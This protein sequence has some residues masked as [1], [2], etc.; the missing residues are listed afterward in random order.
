MATTNLYRPTYAES[1]ALVIGIDDYEHAPPLAHAKNDAEAFARVLVE[2]FQF[3]EANL[4]ILT[5][6]DATRS[7][8]LR[9]FMKYAQ[10]SHVGSDDRIIVFFAGHGHTVPARRGETGFLVPADGDPSDL[11]TLLRWDEL[12]RN[13]DLIPAKHMFF[14]M[15]ACYGG[16]ALTR[17]PLPAGSMRFLRDMLQ[18][19]SRQVLTAGKGDEAVADA[20]GPRPHHSLFTGHLLDALEG[21]AATQGVIT[22][23]GVMAYVYHKVARDQYS[24]QTPHYGFLEGDGDFVF[25]ANALSD[26]ADDVTAT[27]VPI[28]VTASHPADVPSPDTVSDTLKELLATPSQQI[29]L[30]DFASAQIRSAL[31]ATSLER[32]PVRDV[33]IT[34]EALASR[35]ASY[36][37]AIAN[38]ATMAVLMGRWCTTEQLPILEKTLGRVAEGDKGSSGSVLWLRLG[39]YPTLYLMYSAGVAALSA[40]NYAAL[41]TILTTRVHTQSRDRSELRPLA[42]AIIGELRDIEDAFKQLPGHERHRVPRSEYLR[43]RQQPLLEDLLF[44]GRTYDRHFDRFEMF[45][46][47]TFADLKE[48][49]WG[50]PGRFAWKHSQDGRSPYVELIEEAARMGTE[51][52][53][54]KVGLFRGSAQRFREVAGE[55]KKFLD[56]LNWW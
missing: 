10:D 26:D 50:P 24:Q 1:H 21:A 34:N 54:F 3:T 49:P 30:D 11:S 28:T 53:P 20:N 38:L 17:S 40:D 15:D 46:A 52:P 44:L 22:A 29:R 56:Q 6:G 51:W 55:Y 4:T 8:L 13:A 7:G 19:F 48:S 42:V 18:R 35:I 5:D 37:A 25:A 14:V 12:T 33:N 43:T 47:L 27:D 16:L 32:F 45:L 36:E 31:D 2:R 39:W 23:S 41:A 9:A